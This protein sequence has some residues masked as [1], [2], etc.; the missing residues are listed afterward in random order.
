MN[1]EIKEVLISAGKLIGIFAICIIAM[2]AL[3][4]AGEYGVRAGETNECRQWAREAKEY[5]G[6][7][8]TGWQKMQCEARG[9]KVDARVVE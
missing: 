9:I 5:P 1:E 4:G 6:Y 8:I 3:I 2:A 7:Y